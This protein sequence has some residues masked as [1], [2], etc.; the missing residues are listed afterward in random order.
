MTTFRCQQFY[1]LAYAYG[2]AVSQ[3]GKE[4]PLAVQLKG[5]M[6][7]HLHTCEGCYDE[8]ED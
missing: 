1:N 2:Q 7:E 4:S 6:D 8:E 3:H 5:K